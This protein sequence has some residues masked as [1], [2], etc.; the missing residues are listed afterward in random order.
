MTEL[1]S[2]LSLYWYLQQK[3]KLYVDAALYICYP[4]HIPVS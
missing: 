3:I 2:D 1:K 4:T